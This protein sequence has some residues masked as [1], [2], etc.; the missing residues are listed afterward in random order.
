MRPRAIACLV[1]L[2]SLACGDASKPLRPEQGVDSAAD[3]PQR[4]GGLSER[5]ND[6]ATDAATDT[7]T[8]TATDADTD[9]PGAEAGPQCLRHWDCPQTAFCFDGRCLVDP[10]Q[11]LYH[12]GK[13]DLAGNDSC[14]PGER[15]VTA[16]GASSRCAASLSYACSTACDCGPAHCCIEVAGQGR[17]CVKD[18]LDPLFPGGGGAPSVGCR[19]LGAAT[20]CATAPSCDEAL[21]GYAEKQLT[22]AFRAFDPQTG[23]SSA[24]CAGARCY[25][26]SCQCAPGQACVDTEVAQPQAERSC[27][28]LNGGSC[29]SNAMAQ[30]VFGYQPQDLLP[31]CSDA[32]LPG[33]RC[34]AG[35]VSDRQYAYRRVVRECGLCGNG[36]CD[37]GEY[38]KD[39]PQDC[40]CGDGRCDPEEVGRCE[41]DCGRKGDGHCDAHEIKGLV[42]YYFGADCRCGNGSCDAHEETLERCP[43]DCRCGDGFCSAGE[44]CPQDCVC[45]DSAALPLEPRVCGD[46][47]CERAHCGDRESCK[48]CSSDCGPCQWVVKADRYGAY[49]VDSSSLETLRAVWGFGA[50]DLYAAGDYGQILHFD[51]LAWQ[52]M[53]HVLPKKWHIN[54]LWGASPSQLF[55]IGDDPSSGSPVM[56]FDG[57]RWSEVPAGTHEKGDPPLA[58]NGIWGFGPDSI[59]AVGPGGRIMRYQGGTF[60][61]MQSPTRADLYGIW[62]ADPE[63]LHAVGDEVLLHYDG[64]Q[65]RVEATPAKL[66]ALSGSSAATIF[67]VG[68][69]GSVRRFDGL[70]W[71]GVVAPPGKADLSAVWV[72]SPSSVIAVGAGG[73]IFSFD[74]A[75]WTELPSPTLR[76]LRS[77]WAGKDIA[78]AVGDGGIAADR[79]QG[80]RRDHPATLGAI[81]ALWGSTAGEVFAVG[82]GGMI[83]ERQGPDWVPL[84]S[85]VDRT[86]NGIWGSSRADI[87]AV[88][89][90]GTIVHFDGSRWQL[91]PSPTT[92]ELFGVWGSGPDDIVAVGGDFNRPGVL[93]HFDGKSWKEPTLGAAY[94]ALSAVWGSGAKDVFAV[95]TAGTILHYNGSHWTGNEKASVRVKDGLRSVW[96]SG[97]ANVYAL[98]FKSILHFDGAAWQ[99]QAE[100]EGGPLNQIWGPSAGEVFAVGS[101]GMLLRLEG[102]TWRHAAVDLR[103]PARATATVPPWG[104]TEIRAIWGASRDE[105]LLA[106]DLGTILRLSSTP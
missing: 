77:L 29:I 94:G 63:D 76:S 67:A 100:V 6:A 12:C 87:W 35:W 27:A 93:L 80:W 5:P 2:L 70:R 75:S 21:R 60:V 72:R 57:L 37:P 23:E 84:P 66:R 56:R 53:P 1:A 69:A 91:T 16:G 71:A 50:N 10:E 46:G 32:C 97:P 62:G 102:A 52:P 19:S 45:A 92:S 15:C 43:A 40:R 55:A 49:S 82:S 103:A 11:K 44:D 47:V 73:R 95:G 18:P 30:A 4:D 106:G 61:P 68:T 7:D 59:F 96:G 88:G 25:G 28:L 3:L 81:N 98:G 79:G 39:C 58:L 8:D 22:S 20:Y 48:T 83:V 17:R 34:D 42:P 86:L 31:C 78:V 24:R 65:W 51:G 105:L 33:T 26:T 14:P 99:L 74:G 104:C 54:A 41:A 89:A 13:K 85:G 38:R 36:H 64:K 101:N 90:A 9:T